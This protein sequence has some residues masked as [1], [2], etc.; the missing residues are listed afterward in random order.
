MTFF[1]ILDNCKFHNL[2]YNFESQKS[3]HDSR[4]LSLRRKYIYRRAM[5]SINRHGKKIVSVTTVAE[6][7]KFCPY[8]GL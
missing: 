7:K 1:R 5:G 2:D 4:F 6:R 8:S 3:Y